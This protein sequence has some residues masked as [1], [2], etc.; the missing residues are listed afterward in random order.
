MSE[1]H[2][3]FLRMIGRHHHHRGGGGPFGGGAGGDDD[4]GDSRGGRDDGTRVGRMFGHGD[5]R[6]V[7]LALIEK[8]ARHGY[9][10]IRLIEEMSG[11]AYTPSPGAIYPT[12]TLLEEAGHA[13]VANTVSNRKQYKITDEGR[14]YLDKNR[15]AAESLVARMDLA[16][17]MASKMRLPAT[18]RTAFRQ[19]KTAVLGHPHN[20][21]AEETARVIGIIERAAAEIAHPANPQTK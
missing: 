16:G 20:W 2:H 11:G 5:L 6:L 21:D 9:E 10:L 7:L 17:R 1:H 3:H 14:A 4:F 15:D 18:L 8:E 12:L 19:L 13:E